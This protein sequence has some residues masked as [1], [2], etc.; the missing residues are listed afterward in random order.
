MF[1][2]CIAGAAFSTAAMADIFTVENKCG[3]FS[4]SN[5]IWVEGNGKNCLNGHENLH[6]GKN[7][8]YLSMTQAK[9]TYSVTPGSQMSHNFLSLSCTNVRAGQTVKFVKKSDYLSNCDCVQ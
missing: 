4:D 5:V 3:N 9:C 6:S 1:I 2:A 8:I 7:E